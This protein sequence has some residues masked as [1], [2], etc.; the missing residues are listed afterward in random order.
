MFLNFRFKNNAENK[1]NKI[2]FPSITFTVGRCRFRI[3]RSNLLHLRRCKICIERIHGRAMRQFG[4]TCVTHQGTLLPRLGWNLQQSRTQSTFTKT[5]VSRLFSLFIFFFDKIYKNFLFKYE[6]IWT[7][8]WV[9][10]LRIFFFYGFVSLGRHKKVWNVNKHMFSVMFETRLYGKKWF[11]ADDKKICEKYS[12][13]KSF[14]GELKYFLLNSFFF[15]VVD[16]KKKLKEKIENFI[17]TK[18]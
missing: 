5:R 6:N 2:K 14:L 4:W 16:V 3:N 11:V 10:L 12:N 7:W 18:F 8:C 15:D 13:G 9:D 1:K 17:F